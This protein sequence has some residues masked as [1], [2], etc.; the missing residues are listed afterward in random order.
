MSDKILVSFRVKKPDNWYTFR[1]L[2]AQQHMSANGLLNKLVD[3]Y[4]AR[5]GVKALSAYPAPD[6]DE[7][8]TV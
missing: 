2:A 4:V 3:Q 6:A 1:L 8:Q 5:H 7:P